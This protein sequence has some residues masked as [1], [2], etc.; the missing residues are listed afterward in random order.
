MKRTQKKYT[1][2]IGIPAYNE[3]KN[4]GHLLS[5]ILTQKVKSVVVEKIIVASDGSTD[6]TE[7]I[8][9]SFKDKRIRF[10]NHKER[11]GKTSLDNELV[12]LATTDILVMLDADVLP[13]ANNFLEALCR[14]IIND[15][16]V[17]LVGGRVHPAQPNSFFERVIAY[18]HIVKRH[19]FKQ[20][21]GG[22]T[23]YLCHGRVRAFSKPVYKTISWP[24]TCPEDAYSY[25]HCKK[26]GY[27]FFYQKKASV[28]FR[29]PTNLLDHAKQSKRFVSGKAILRK[30]FSE[31][32]VDSSYRL[33]GGKML[34]SSFQF[35]LR[36]PVSFIVYFF[37]QTYVRFVFENVSYKRM[38]DTSKST[39]RL[40]SWPKNL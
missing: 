12:R 25:L 14:P 31:E 27:S 40:I 8:V 10:I 3:E 39:K 32:I 19:L 16:K 34:M 20:I 30:Y 15:H 26:Q 18:S 1:V 9:S 24:L 37:I 21:N 36:A 29:A 4:I 33:P 35:F 7:S 38:Y 6:A 28:L 17:G 11:R 2:S 23:I 13:L 22:D 5:R